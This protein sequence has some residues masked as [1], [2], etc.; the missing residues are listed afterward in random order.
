MEL[1]L[2]VKYGPEF[3]NAMCK[4]PEPKRLVE[5][6]IECL[7]SDWSNSPSR[8][9]SCLQDKNF[10]FYSKN[11]RKFDDIQQYLILFLLSNSYTNLN[12]KNGNERA[13]INLE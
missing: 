3:G 8:I 10:A 1:L 11:N 12:V 2:K 4:D 13:R 5:C 7:R 9:E 6:D